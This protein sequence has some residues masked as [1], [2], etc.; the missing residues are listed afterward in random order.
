MKKFPRFQISVLILF[1]TVTL[2]VIQ[3]GCAPSRQTK[4]SLI[5][6]EQENAAQRARIFDDKCRIE[7]FRR[8][9]ASLKKRIRTLEDQL[10]TREQIPNRIQ[11]YS[12]RSSARTDT[13]LRAQSVP[14][15]SPPH[16]ENS[17]L[18]STNNV[19]SPEPPKI[20]KGTP[21]SV[22]PTDIF[23]QNMLTEAPVSASV[24]NLA[25]LSAAPD[26][27]PKRIRVRKTD[28]SSVH[29]V[30]LLENSIR[31]CNYD[32]LYL[33][34]QMFD[35]NHQIILAAA[36]VIVAVTDPSQPQ[37][38]S[39]ISRWI[40][41]AEE[42]AEIINSGEASLS[43]PLGLAWEHGC[44]QN[45]KLKVHIHYST[46]D[47][48]QLIDEVSVNL[49][50]AAFTEPQKGLAAEIAPIHAQIGHAPSQQN[51]QNTQN[52]SN[53]GISKFNSTKNPPTSDQTQ[54]SQISPTIKRP[55]WTPDPS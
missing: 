44:P 4:Q 2:T 24:G 53:F 55:V 18:P 11:N 16:T 13:A 48:R 36:P 37:E 40:F 21:S 41:T 51:T 5:C 14:K 31:P 17:I 22:T 20:E 32:G 49:Q 27:L 38:H 50:E 28:S 39:L 54:H 10:A 30:R 52:T 19:I 15:K 1:I 12:S 47:N 42:I 25:R 33:N 3:G 6:L 29:R 34:F 8:E 7:E 26:S 43:V 35:E 9:N 46:S 45:L 23:T